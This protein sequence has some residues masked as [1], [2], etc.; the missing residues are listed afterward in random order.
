LLVLFV[1]AALAAI[2]WVLYQHHKNLTY[3]TT[4]QPQNTTTTQSTQITTQY[5][6]IKEWG[7]KLPLSDSI[8]DAYYIVSNGSAD[9]NGQPNTMWL[10][11]SSLSGDCNASQ[12]NAPG[13]STTSAVG[14]LGR[15]LPTDHDP[16]LQKPYTQLYPGVTIGQYYYFYISNTKGKTC[17][18]TTTLQSVDSAFG[19]DAKHIVPT[20]QYL[21]IKEWGVHLTL[22]STTASLY[23]YIKPDL[24]NVAY[25]SLKT[26]SDV[27]PKCAANN[28]PLG[29]ISR[30][31]PTEHQS[32]LN[33][34]I[35]SIPGTI[36]I[37]N[38]WYGY[39][40]SHAACT[41]GTAA[42]NAAVSKAAPNYNPGVL[43]NTLNTLAADPSTN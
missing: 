28:G 17:A 42:M 3:H 38:Y 31:T 22:D 13:A 43:L 19:T 39:E 4:S 34:S 16:V 8:K 11:L 41:D 7:V 2:G 26:I 27:A 6:T 24:P 15:A 40:G 18:P 35:H 33:G 21:T 1:V 12:A 29:A 37:G 36:Q 32:A 20:T 10:G 14:A 9:A 30:L 23:Y 25:L 5:L